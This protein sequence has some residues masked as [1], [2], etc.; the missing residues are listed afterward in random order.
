MPIFR[1]KNVTRLALFASLVALVAACAPARA[2]PD[3]HLSD[4]RPMQT[5]PLAEAVPLRV[6]VAAVIS[7]RGT[8]ESYRPLLDY[9]ADRMGRPVAL[10][11]RRTYAEV[12]QLIQDGQVDLAFVCTSAYVEG[13]DAFG[14]ELIAAP[15]V[16]GHT[17]YHSVLIVPADSPARSMNDLR[18]KVFAFTDPMSLSG[19]VYPSSIVRDQGSTPEQFFARTYF[20]YSHDDAIRAVADGVADGAMVDSLVYD[21]AIARDPDLAAR[22][23]LIDRSPPFG[24]PPAVVGPAVRPQVKAELRNLLLTL[25]DDPDPRAA[26]ALRSIGVERFVTIEDGAYASVRDLLKRLQ[27]VAA[28]EA[29]P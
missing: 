28:A 17:V 11:Q 6:A 21:F 22:T 16:N 1:V 10:V 15:Q 3:I 7:P 19:R 5:T 27:P 23:R 24:I 13:R 29:S 26:Q 14:M 18:D 9:I 20:T 8:A 25:A 2:D 4:L 12:N